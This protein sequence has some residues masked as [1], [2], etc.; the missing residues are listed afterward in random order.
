MISRPEPLAVYV[1]WPWCL[2]KCPYCDFN[3]HV[4]DEIPRGE[5]LAALF[6]QLRATREL[7][8]ARDVVSVFVGGGTP[9]LMGAEAVGEVLAEISQLWDI[10]HGTEITVECNPTS[11][12]RTLFEGL[13]RAGVN[14][15]SIGVQST[16]ADW[17]EFLGRKH[18][19][20][21]AMATLDAAQEVIGNVN[22]DLIFGLPQQVLEDWVVQLETLAGRGLAHMSCYQLTIE[23]QTRFWSAVKRGEWMPMEDDLQAE[24]ITATRAVLRRKYRNYEVSNFAQAGK[25]CRHNTHVWRYG[26]YAGVGAG[27]HGRLTLDGRRVATQVTKHPR[28]YLANSAA[29]RDV[30]KMADLSHKQQWKE[31]ILSGLRLDEGIDV[32][33]ME[34]RLGGKMTQNVDEAVWRSFR[35]AGFLDNTEKRLK[36]ADSGWLVLDAVLSQLL[37]A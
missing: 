24:F 22:A 32:A 9:S 34:K 7:T 33:G 3:A 30:M 4:W 13:Q 26:D 15:V 2:A 8:G 36:L 1:H 37:V 21:Q 28:N 31:A 18:D 23:P 25:E 35:Q 5:Y 6:K 16:R 11:S 10:P 17:L 19:V 14:R 12:S 20:T 27:A 29:G